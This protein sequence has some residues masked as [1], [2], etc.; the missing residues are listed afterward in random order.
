M[1]E[2]PYRIILIDDNHTTN[3]L[4]E[5]VINRSGHNI[6]VS[7]FDRAINAVDFFSK[8]EN[9]K[10]SYLIFLDINMP[11]MDGWEFADEYVKINTTQN[12]VIVMLTSSVDP[13]DKE[14]ALVHSAIYEYHPKPLTFEVLNEV[15]AKYF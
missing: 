10:N 3:F 4:N 11:E 8:A 6:E 13:R 14:R 5:M 12:N 2:K 9:Q 7:S 1:K 15:L